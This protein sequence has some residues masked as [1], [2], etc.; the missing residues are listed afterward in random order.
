MIKCL[1][2]HQV[3]DQEHFHIRIRL[4]EF[5]REKARQRAK[6]MDAIRRNRYKVETFYCKCCDITLKKNNRSRH[7]QSQKHEENEQKMEERN[8]EIFNE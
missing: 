4:C 1:R 2:C 7:F 3:Y 6:E 8:S 5:C